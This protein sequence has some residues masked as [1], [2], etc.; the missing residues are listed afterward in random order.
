MFASR[1]RVALLLLIGATA[2]P[3]A[4]Q[5]SADGPR[6]QAI[7]MPEWPTIGAPPNA[8]ASRYDAAVEPAIDALP[9]A[10]PPQPEPRPAPADRRLAPRDEKSLDRSAA[11]RLNPSRLITDFG[12]QFD[13]LYSTL[14]ALAIVLGLFFVCIWALRRGARKTI[15]MLPS[16][17]VAVLGRVTLAPKQFAELLRIGN[18]LVLVAETPDGPRLLAEVTDPAEVDRLM[19]LCQQATPHSASQD[20]DRLFRELANDPAPAGFLG[21]EVPVISVQA[22]PPSYRPREGGR[23]A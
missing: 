7:S 15:H 22:D 5:V 1:T 20:F 10:D 21:G 8:E 6:A 18:K 2:P 17:V 19:G 11:Q 9:P 13:S 14:A 3:A 16:T 4:A 12:L 23:R